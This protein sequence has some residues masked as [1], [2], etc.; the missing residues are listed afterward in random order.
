MT[1]VRVTRVKTK[2]LPT[3]HVGESEAFEYTIKI[4][5][6][7]NVLDRPEE[8]AVNRHVLPDETRRQLVSW[9]EGRG[10]W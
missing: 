3:N 1:V 2:G 4:R 10:D 5:Q 9:L 6:W 8:P 7:E